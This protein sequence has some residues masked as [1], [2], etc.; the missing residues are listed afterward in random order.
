[1]GDIDEPAPGCNM[2][3]A[4]CIEHLEFD[5]TFLS[6]SQSTV[7]CSPKVGQSRSYFRFVVAATIQSK[8]HMLMVHV[9]GWTFFGFLAIQLA[10]QNF[11]RSDELTK[12]S[13]VA[14]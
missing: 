12:Y 4:F 7:H 5:C 2:V 13:Y 9:S 6:N 8:F 1:V 11:G 14:W 10:L 3:L